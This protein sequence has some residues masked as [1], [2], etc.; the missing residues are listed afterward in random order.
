MQ[1]YK[2]IRRQ[3]IKSRILNIV[4]AIRPLR[5]G[6]DI[7][8]TIHRIREALL[9]ITD[10]VAGRRNEINDRE[11]V[12]KFVSLLASLRDLRDVRPPTTQLLAYCDVSMGVFLLSALIDAFVRFNYLSTNDAVELLHAIA[13][14]DQRLREPIIV[15]GERLLV[16]GNADGA[17]NAAREAL[18]RESACPTAQNLLLKAARAVRQDNGQESVSDIFSG[19]LREYFCTRPFQVL[20]SGQASKFDGSKEY[21]AS[22]LCDCGGWLSYPAGN[23]IEA[24]SVDDVWNSNAAQEIRR[25][26]IDGDFSY[27][28]RTLC[29]LIVGKALPK[30]A[31][32]KDETL[33]RIIDTRTTRLDYMPKEVQI[34]HDSSCNIACPSCRSNIIMAKNS[35]RERFAKAKDRVILPMLRKIEGTCLITG[36][37]DPLGSHHY[38]S[39]I[40]ELD[41]ATT[42]GLR[43]IVVTN[44]LLLTENEWSAL[45][46]LRLME[47]LSVSID[48]ASRETYEIVRRPGKWDVLLTNLDFLAKSS[49]ALE[50]SRYSS[51]TFAC[52]R[53]I[54]A[55]CRRSCVWPRN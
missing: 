37:G 5:T 1:I 55:R 21:G 40:A 3:K 41:P 52:R 47:H 36:F 44:G 26:I 18:G 25:S 27:C 12:A 29:P 11:L 15:H 19:D 13:N 51:S 31:E 8:D 32:V 16:S 39:I 7:S 23:I 35:E 50:N 14:V 45:P 34:S 28:S 43:L 2:Q 4:R 30:R 42:P 20:N 48:A 54:S 46:G 22:Y 6:A 33:R 24:E 53:S 17:A 10:S 9:E 38:R 49:G